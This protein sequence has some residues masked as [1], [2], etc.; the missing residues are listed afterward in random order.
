ML[1]HTGTSL[2]YWSTGAGLEPGFT[3]LSLV[4]GSPEMGLGPRSVGEPGSWTH[5]SQP[6]IRTT[7]IGLVAR[8]V[9]AS[10]VLKWGWILISRESS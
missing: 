7:G 8:C 1:E 9:G 3:E 10:L 5:R 6:G 2:V 4:L